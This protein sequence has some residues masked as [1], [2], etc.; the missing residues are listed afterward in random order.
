MSTT[1]TYMTRQSLD[2]DVAKK[3][4]SSK[5]LFPVYMC[6]GV[7]VSMFEWGKKGSAWKD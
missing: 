6:V 7:Y 4:V 5:T 2:P 3:Q 1:D